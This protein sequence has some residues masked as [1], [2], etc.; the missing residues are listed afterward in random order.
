MVIGNPSKQCINPVY[1]LSEDQPSEL[2]GKSQFGEGKPLAGSAKKGFG[3]AVGPTDDEGDLLFPRIF[4]FLKKLGPFFGGFVSSPLIEDH[5]ITIF[6]DSLGQKLTLTID[7]DFRLH[8]FANGKVPDLFDSKLNEGPQA[9]LIRL[10]QL[11]NR[12]ALESSNDEESEFHE[13][14]YEEGGKK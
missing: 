3:N 4:P 2:M 11:A 8:P 6:R 13:M 14:K 1:L 5:I 12:L 9:L 7:G 10:A